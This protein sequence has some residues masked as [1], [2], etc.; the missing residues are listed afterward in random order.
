MF[1]LRL[2]QCQ[3]NVQ[4]RSKQRQINVRIT[5]NVLIVQGLAFKQIMIKW[6][7]KNILGWL[8]R[9]ARHAPRNSRVKYAV[10]SNLTASINP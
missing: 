8:A 10:G 7:Q 5:F 3:I 4:I 6:H 9:L 1:K 2:K